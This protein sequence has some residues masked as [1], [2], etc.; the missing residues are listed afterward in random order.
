MLHLLDRGWQ[1][2]IAVVNGTQR[3]ARSSQV[4]R[5]AFVLCRGSK[6]SVRAEAREEEIRAARERGS[7]VHFPGGR[8][9]GSGKA[10]MISRERLER[11]APGEDHP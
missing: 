8:Q 9:R 10:A 5:Q 4:C 1:Q 6:I 7:Q 11:T 2:A 3:T